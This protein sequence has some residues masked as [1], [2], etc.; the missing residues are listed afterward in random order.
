VDGDLVITLFRHGLTIANERKT[1]LGWSDSPLSMEGKKQLSPLENHPELVFSSDLKRC[2]DTA[3]ILFPEKQAI[4]KKE[5]RE[6]HFG[7]WEGKTYEQLKEDSDY[8]N[9]ISQPFAV[10]PPGG[11]SFVEFADRIESGWETIKEVM[12][13]SGAK[14]AAIVTHGGVIRYFLMKYA[15]VEKEFWEWSI[16]HGTGWEMTFKE[17]D[18]RRGRRCILLREVLITANPDGPKNTIKEKG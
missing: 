9:W 12:M 16:P 2:I 14:R 5:L 4:R 8:Q 6:I 10:T 15:P 17:D 3:A 7:N 1:Y 11:E 18:F 13:A